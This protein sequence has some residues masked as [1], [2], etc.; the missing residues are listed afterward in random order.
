MGDLLG[1]QAADHTQRQR[2][3]P[4]ARQ[5]R[6][7]RDEDQPQHVV[8]DAVGIPAGVDVDLGFQLAGQ[9]GVPIVEA[10]LAAPLVDGLALGDRRQPGAGVARHARLR[11]LRQRVDER[12]LRQ[13]F[14]EADIA[15]RPGQ[16][17]DDL[18]GLHPPHRVDGLAQIG[19][20]HGC[21][22]SYFDLKNDSYRRHT[23]YGEGP[24]VQIARLGAT[25][26]RQPQRLDRMVSLS[27]RYRRAASPM[28]P[29]VTR[30]VRR[31]LPRCQPHRR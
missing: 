3:L 5:H 13:V 1:G 15:D 8:I 19:G 16:R 21:H 30:V 6:V 27:C 7:G 31:A 26:Q 12:L 10:V 28:S 22:A 17:R 20:G 24:I 25:A 4:L 9:R 23:S 14:G 29:L 2:D 11:P 18:G